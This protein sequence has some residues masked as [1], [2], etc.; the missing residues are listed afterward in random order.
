MSTASALSVEA[1]PVVVATIPYVAR[2]EPAPRVY[3][4]EPPAG[5]PWS[6]LRRDPRPMPVHDVRGAEDRF[7]LAADGVCFPTGSVPVEDTD[8]AVV[9]ARSYPALAEFARE[10]TGAEAVTITGHATRRRDY[11]LDGGRRTSG[12]RRDIADFA[13]ADQSEASA[14]RLVRTADPSWNGRPFSITKFWTPLQ[15]PV[16]DH[17]LTLCLGTTYADFQPIE[18]IYGYGL[19]ILPGLA[20]DPTHHWVYKS[21][22]QVGELLAF[23]QWDSRATADVIVGHVAFELPETPLEAPPRHSFEFTAV[24]FF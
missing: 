21:A 15:G 7:S 20:H 19:E 16:H 11:A 18:N 4:V 5:T 22:L 1:L 13:H 14:R 9:A 2:A 10:I 17:P 6:T 23:R 24:S 12:A 8:P 3:Y